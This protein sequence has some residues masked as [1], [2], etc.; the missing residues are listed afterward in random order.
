MLHLVEGKVTSN[1]DDTRNGRFYAHFYE[2]SDT[3]IE[4]YISSPGYREGGGGMF[5]VPS[6]D[7]RIIAFYD[8]NKN[9]AYYNSTIIGKPT[10]DIKE[11]P[12]L[13]K[14]AGSETSYNDYSIPIKVKYQDQVGAGLCITNET[15]SYPEIDARLGSIMGSEGRSISPRIIKSVVLNSNLNKRLSLDDSPQTDAIFIKNQHKDGIIIMGTQPRPSP[16][17]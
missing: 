9:V 7:D 15:T 1:V 10:E 5:F 3:P 13:R 8:N 17:K 6:R 16:L 11:V 12:N 14:V 2:I 4:V